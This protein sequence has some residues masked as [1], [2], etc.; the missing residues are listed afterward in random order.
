MLFKITAIA[1]ALVASVS[2]HMTMIDPC[3]RFSPWCV[4]EPAT[5]PA[6][7]QLDYSIKS[8]IPADGILCKSNTPWSSPVAT[9]TAGQSVTVQFY[10]DGAAHGGGHTQFSVSYD[11]GKT[12]AVVYEVL[13]YMFFNGPSSGNTPEVLSYTFT[14]PKEL[15]NSDSVVFAWSWVNAI[16][17]REFYMN[18]ADV[19][20]TGSSS[21]SY[22]GKQMV[23]ADHN[24]YPTIPEF[25]GDYTTGLSYYENAASVTVSPRGSSTSGGNGTYAAT[26]AA[27]PSA[28][29]EAPS[30]VT[31]VGHLAQAASSTVVEEVAVSSAPAAVSPTLAPVSSAPAVVE[32]ATAADDSSAGSDGDDVSESGSDDS[33]S[34]SGCTH[35]TMACAADGSGYQTCVWGTWSVVINCPTKTRCK[36]FNGSIICDWA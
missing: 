27:S 17:N 30:A 14:L 32:P 16:G 29:Y 18:C 12:F 1:A 10:P 20:I 7:A 21:S 31:P 15:P 28:N 25:N 6:G 3:P 36:P 34:S 13:K 33:S 24:G 4:H 2:A 11:G 35:G 8:P 9:W 23:I 5:L 19:A 26:P 22:T